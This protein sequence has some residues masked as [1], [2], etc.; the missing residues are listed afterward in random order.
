MAK[1]KVLL[2]ITLIMVFIW[3][4]DVMANTN[5]Q[6]IYD[7]LCSQIGNEYGVCALMGNLQAESGILSYRLQGDFTSG[8]TKSLQYTESVDNGTITREQF[9]TDSKGYGLAQWTSS[10]RK[11]GYYDHCISQG[12]SI[13]DTD[14]AVQYLMIELNSPSYSNVLMA[15]RNA[16]SIRD[17][18]DIVL[19]YYE[20]PKDQSENVK[21]YRASLGITLYNI[22]A[23]GIIPPMPD[24]PAPTPTP[25]TNYSHII[26]LLIGDE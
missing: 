19:K 3:S 8:Y 22:Y 26:C 1:K 25:T 16:T 17:A 14:C 10:N 4:R 11:L 9:G 24:P 21:R 12:K 7:Y 13:G 15:L 18:S 2:T 20:S 5:T 6:Y 23:T